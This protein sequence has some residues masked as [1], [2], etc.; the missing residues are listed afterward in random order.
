MAFL[1]WMEQ[2]GRG[3]RGWRVWEVERR[4][5]SHS[6]GDAGGSLRVS[7]R[8]WLLLRSTVISDPGSQQI[9]VLCLN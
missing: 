7:F 3:G 6:Q 2:C 1:L 4:L 8:L 5:T 9:L